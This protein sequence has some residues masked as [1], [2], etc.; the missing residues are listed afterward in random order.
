MSFATLAAHSANA[1]GWLPSDI[2]NFDSSSTFI[3]HGA[4]QAHLWPWQ[5]LRNGDR[6][7]PHYYMKQQTA[8]V[9]PC[10]QN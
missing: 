3:S 4:A 7:S 10:F 8:L 5:L 1:R 2:T 6:V 9:G